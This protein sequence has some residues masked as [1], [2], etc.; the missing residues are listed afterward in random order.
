MKKSA[1]ILVMI[2]LT[3]CASPSKEKKS[4]SCVEA[5]YLSLKLLAEST[6]DPCSICAKKLKRQAFS[7]IDEEFK[8]GRILS[9]GNDCSIV[10][11]E[12]CDKN[13]F[14]ISSYSNEEYVTD[15]RGEKHPFPAFLFRF[16]TRGNHLVGIS[17][18][19][20]TE[21]SLAKSYQKIKTGESA[22]GKALI[23]KYEYG[24]GAA[25]NYF[26]ER[27]ALVVHVKIVALGE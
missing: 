20:Y 16:H 5:P 24:D 12:T 11:T 8:P 22:R 9:F 26:D 21:E 15:P 19:D 18:A 14:T 23:I 1:C 7:I 25:A 27:N 10:K 13:E 2:V 17:S 3:A 6:I 4:H